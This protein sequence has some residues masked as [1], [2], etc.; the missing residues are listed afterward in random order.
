M[1]PLSIEELTDAG[2]SLTRDEYIF[3]GF[4]PRLYNENI[5]PSL[6]Y[7]AYYETY[8]ERDVRKLINVGN[9]HA[10]EVFLKL[11]A[12]RVGQV[13]NMSDLAGSTGVSSTTINSWLSVLEA[14]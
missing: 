4:M 10:I 9:Q 6:L 7:P 11:L 13:I 5:P 12:G 2:I 14:S 1:F 3:N 8:V